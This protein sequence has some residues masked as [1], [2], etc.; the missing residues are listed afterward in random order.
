MSNGTRDL[1]FVCV[2]IG[3]ELAI[4]IALIHL[5]VSPAIGV[6]VVSAN[7]AAMIVG[8]IKLIY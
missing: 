7:M 1:L 4:T 6:P 3:V 2:L 5:G 8:Y